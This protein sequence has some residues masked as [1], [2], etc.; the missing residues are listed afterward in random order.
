MA[1]ILA[2]VSARV[3]AQQTFARPA[4]S[5]GLEDVVQQD[6][7][8]SR[9]PSRASELRLDLSNRLPIQ[10]P[11]TARS[12]IALSGWRTAREW[13]TSQNQPPSMPGSQTARS[14]AHPGREARCAAAP[15]RL[16]QPLRLPRGP[17]AEPPAHSSSS[18]E[19]SLQQGSCRDMMGPVMS[20]SGSNSGVA[21]SS[22]GH[23]LG[24]P[25]EQAAADDSGVSNSPAGNLLKAVPRTSA[26]AQPHGQA[27]Q[28]GRAAQG[29]AAL[30]QASSQASTEAHDKA[31]MPAEQM[32]EAAQSAAL[33]G[34]PHKQ[35]AGSPCWNA[36]VPASDWDGQVTGANPAA[37]H[38]QKPASNVHHQPGP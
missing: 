25:L 28:M 20:S 11:A 29:S 26:E 7:E 2:G 32:T 1:N 12:R 37:A 24:H 4:A 17:T 9:N 31:V 33:Q 19:V 6:V 15:T 8:G 38:S 3:Q 13:A 36:G 10:T 21:G 35:G 16:D 34:Q 30:F 23:P 14:N 5:R 22:G 27:E 18:K